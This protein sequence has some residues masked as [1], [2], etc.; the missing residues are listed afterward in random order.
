MHFY[1][2]YKKWLNTKEKSKSKPEHKNHLIA[3]F[4]SYVVAKGTMGL[5]HPATHQSK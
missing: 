3:M 5:L 2:I 1:N 4:V